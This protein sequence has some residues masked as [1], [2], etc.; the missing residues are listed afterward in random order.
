MSLG[1]AKNQSCYPLLPYFSTIRVT[2]IEIWVLHNP[3][4]LSVLFLGSRFPETADNSV[5]AADY[6]YCTVYMYRYCRQIW[7]LSCSLLF[8]A[9][10]FPCWHGL[11]Y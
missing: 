6:I 10:Q 3:K 5:E 1:K 9:F 11:Q 7:Y 2:L 8:F 4:L